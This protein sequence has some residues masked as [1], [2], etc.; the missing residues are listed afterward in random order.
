MT[1]VHEVLMRAER[2]FAQVGIIAR[3]LDNCTWE[4]IRPEDH[5]C[6]SWLVDELSGLGKRL[7]KTCED[8]YAALRA[9]ANQ[10]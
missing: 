5:E 3:L 8:L 1:E 9:P 10:I 7:N 2:E 4:T 6:V